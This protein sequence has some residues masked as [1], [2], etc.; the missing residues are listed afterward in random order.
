[1][2]YNTFMAAVQVPAEVK[3][4]EISS[5]YEA[6]KQVKDKRGQ[7]GDAIRRPWP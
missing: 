6:L 2:E 1:M 5:L 7:R 4:V 3:E